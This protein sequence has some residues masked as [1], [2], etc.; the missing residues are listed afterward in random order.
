MLFGFTT[1]RARNEWYKR[2]SRSGALALLLLLLF[3]F[4]SEGRYGRRK[5]NILINGTVIRMWYSMISILQWFWTKTV[6][7]FHGSEEL[8]GFIKM[9]VFF[10][11]FYSR[12]LLITQ[13]KKRLFT[14]KII[15]KKKR[16]KFPGVGLRYVTY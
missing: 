6:A 16:L 7:W 13:K 2:K 4:P 12:D 9:P 15:M 3:F 14:M 11:F 1:T 8:V 10:N 5:K